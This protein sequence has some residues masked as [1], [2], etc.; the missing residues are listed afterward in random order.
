MES[1]TIPPESSGISDRGSA[2]IPPGDWIV[3]DPRNGP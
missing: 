2:V 1:L 3:P